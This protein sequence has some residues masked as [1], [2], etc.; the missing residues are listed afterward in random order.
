MTE[1]T[2]EQKLQDVLAAHAEWIESDG[3][4]GTRLDLSDAELSFVNLR[5][6]NL[7]DVNLSGANLKCADLNMAYMPGMHEGRELWPHSQVG[8]LLPPRTLR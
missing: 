2:I 3:K 4:A 6:A 7:T 5:E 8:V 1:Q